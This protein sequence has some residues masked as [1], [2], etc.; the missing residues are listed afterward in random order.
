MTHP[1]NRK[2]PARL[3]ID[4]DVTNEDTGQLETIQLTFRALS[5]KRWNDL[6]TEF[7]ATD[8]QKAAYRLAQLAA[9]IPLGR[10]NDVVWDAERFPP[11]LIAACC[12]DPVIPVDLSIEMWD[13]ENESWTNAEL[14]K[15]F[16][17]A[18]VVNQRA[19]LVRLGK[20]W[21]AILASERN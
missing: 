2:K 15:I 19:D 6:L 10:I 11:Q 5:R 12:V 14:D 13:E 18:L 17:A 4:L 20:E 3:T 7:A 16:S 9:G 8:D 21:E 1:L